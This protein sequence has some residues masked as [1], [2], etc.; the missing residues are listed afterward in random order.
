[1]GQLIEELRSH[2][3]NSASFKRLLQFKAYILGF[4]VL[5]LT[6]AFVELIYGVWTN[7]LGLISDR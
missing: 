2:A 1:M 5:N 4:L 3:A 7:S 6:F